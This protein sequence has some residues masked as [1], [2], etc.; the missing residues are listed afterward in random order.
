MNRKTNETNKI[1]TARISY[2]QLNYDESQMDSDFSHHVGMNSPVMLSR[3]SIRSE[4]Q[5]SKKK[6]KRQIG[7]ISL[8]KPFEYLEVEDY[9]ICPVEA[10]C[11]ALM[12][13]FDRFHLLIHK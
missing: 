7:S 13:P 2:S 3:L 5:K 10:T 1:G 8:R 6:T 11:I 12:D 4:S 9:P